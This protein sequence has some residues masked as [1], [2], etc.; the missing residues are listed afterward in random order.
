MRI[1][2]LAEAT[3][4]TLYAVYLDAASGDLLGIEELGYSPLASY[5]RQ[6]GYFG[7]SGEFD[8]E[9]THKEV[10]PATADS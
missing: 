2:I 6:P 8:G 5:F 9:V 7:P 1:D 4:P 10:D 3:Q